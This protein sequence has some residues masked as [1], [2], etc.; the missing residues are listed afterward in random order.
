MD[1][2][3]LA[4]C[5]AFLLAALGGCSGGDEGTTET[6]TIQTPTGG[7]GATGSLTDGPNNNP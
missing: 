7:S 5:G 2:L 4:L 6:G 3:I 1:R